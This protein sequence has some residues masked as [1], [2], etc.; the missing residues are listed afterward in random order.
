MEDVTHGDIMSPVSAQP[1]PTYGQLSCLGTSVKMMICQPT[2]QLA[3]GTNGQSRNVVKQERK[4]QCPIDF[5]TN[6]T[7][8]TLSVTAKLVGVLICL[9][10]HMAC[11]GGIFAHLLAGASKA[12][13]LNTN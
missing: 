7:L 6:G 1:Q 8:D 3:I 5:I 12:H 9:L 13:C 2:F 11:P 10:I 4:T